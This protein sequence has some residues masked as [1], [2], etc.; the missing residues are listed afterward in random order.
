M[1]D[2]LRVSYDN[3]LCT[4]SLLFIMHLAKI[5]FGSLSHKSK[6]A[7]KDR[8]YTGC[9]LLIYAKRIYSKSI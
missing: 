7:V 5:M 4:I 3:V 9:V 2:P 6:T 8:L 1:R